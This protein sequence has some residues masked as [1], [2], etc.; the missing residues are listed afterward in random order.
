[1]FTD[2]YEINYNWHASLDSWVQI[3]KFKQHYNMCPSKYAHIEL[4]LQNRCKKH[5]V[6]YTPPR[7][8]DSVSA[9]KARRKI[10]NRSIKTASQKERRKNASNE[11]RQDA[12]EQDIM[13]KRKRELKESPDERKSR[14]EHEAALKRRQRERAFK[15]EC[16]DQ[17]VVYTAP[18]NNEEERP[19][20][21]A[22]RKLLRQQFTM[23]T[24]QMA[25]KPEKYSFTC[26]EEGSC[27]CNQPPAKTK[28]AVM[29]T[30]GTPNYASSQTSS[31][32]YIS[33]N[34]EPI[35]TVCYWKRYKAPYIQHTF[36]LNLNN[37][38]ECPVNGVMSAEI[39][40]NDTHALKIKHCTHVHATTNGGNLVI[41]HYYNP[42][43]N[44]SL[45]GWEEKF[46]LE[47]VCARLPTDVIDQANKLIDTWKSKKGWDGHHLYKL[48]SETATVKIEFRCIQFED[49]TI[50]M[51]DPTYSVASDGIHNNKMTAKYGPNWRNTWQQIESEKKKKE[52]EENK[53]KYWMCAKGHRTCHERRYQGMSG[54]FW[55]SET[56]RTIRYKNFGVCLVRYPKCIDGHEICHDGVIQCPSC[57]DAERPRNQICWKCCWCCECLYSI[58]Q[59]EFEE[60]KRKCYWVNNNP[61]LINKRGEDGQFVLKWQR[62]KWYSFGN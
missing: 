48:M 20:K 45:W 33:E 23:V 7:P 26:T 14:L 21:R 29:G 27:D 40:I 57:R 38:N 15:A 49:F 43:H 44:K 39:W 34:V 42:Q 59:S 2:P 46:S 41:T 35:T 13:R 6:V 51:G 47:V 60:H 61:S 18:Q 37:S 25:S 17:E 53:R 10:M 5:G 62:P 52:L 24:P 55:C 58:T 19:M 8:T 32:T 50:R 3:K 56:C 16:L 36:S 9:T 54:D 28:I 4:A 1:M 12:H 11:D 22:R 31:A 30:E